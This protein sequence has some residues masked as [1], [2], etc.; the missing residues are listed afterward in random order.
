ME[1]RATD[2]EIMD[3]G[4]DHY[5]VEEYEQCLHQLGR[6]ARYLGGNRATLAAFKKLKQEPRSI[7]EIGCGGGHFAQILGKKY[8]NAEVLGIDINPLAISYAQ[9]QLNK[10]PNVTYK[11]LSSKELAYP[12]NSFDVVTATVVCHHIPDDELVTFLQECHRIAKKA[13]IIND[14]HRHPLAYLS[15]YLIAPIFFR[16]RLIMHDGLLSIKRAFK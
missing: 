7:L 1:R 3:L 13:V 9:R 5:S 16:N 4:P 15:F 14:L 2:L 10:T 11:C 6:I 12:S 8:P